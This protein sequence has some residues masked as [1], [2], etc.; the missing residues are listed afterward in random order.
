M[1][2]T[3]A[4]S[5]GAAVDASSL[6][7]VRLDEEV[8]QPPL[9]MKELFEMMQGMQ[10]NQ[11]NLAQAIQRIEESKKARDKENPR[12]EEFALEKGQNEKVADNSEKT[13][14]DKASDTLGANNDFQYVTLA[15]QDK[16]KVIV[17][18]VI[19][20]GDEEEDPMIFATLIPATIKTLQRSPA[21]CSLF[22]Q[23]GLTPE[24]RTAATK[25]IV[26]IAS[27]SGSH[28]FTTEA[29]AS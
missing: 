15:E 24:A 3:I 12:R 19:H 1:S 17:A 14:Q 8:E 5:Q 11:D 23:L 28:Y 20:T 26:D 29:H 13:R 9:Q 10:R 25:A 16:E 18:V 7:E 2:H 4:P 22:I 6:R 21:F 27:S